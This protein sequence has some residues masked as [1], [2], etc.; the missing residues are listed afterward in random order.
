MQS[1]III[2]TEHMES[3]KC[4]SDELLK[5]IESIKPDVIFEEEPDDEKYHSYYSVPNSFKSL[6]IRAIIKYKQNH[7]LLNIPVD[8]P[9]NE[10]ASIFLLDNF[11]KLFNRFPEHTKLV[12]EHC[13]LRDNNG[14]IYLNSEEC[15]VLNEKI[16]LVE[17]Q[18]ISKI[19]TAENKINTLYEFFQQ[20]V[21]ARES[22]MIENIYEFSKSNKFKKAVFFI[23]Y[24]HRE[25]LRKKVF[26][27]ATLNINEI[28]WVFYNN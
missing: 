28:Q 15:A 12:K 2:S 21:N 23:G 5:I 27:S 8:K 13:N 24:R 14:F 17:N 6:E 10:Y 19:T 3:G 22:K 26:E 1:I 25:S 4:N 18:I 16:N 9:I 7:S 20:E 11:T